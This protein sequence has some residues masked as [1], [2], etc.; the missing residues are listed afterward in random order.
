ME[1][2]AFN[3]KTPHKN[4]LESATGTLVSRGLFLFVFLW[5]GE[6]VFMQWYQKGG[7]E[8]PSY[9]NQHM[10]LVL[11]F[12]PCKSELRRTVESSPEWKSPNSRRREILLYRWAAIFIIH[13]AGCVPLISFYLKE[14]PAHLHILRKRDTGYEAS[15]F[16]QPIFPRLMMYRLT[17]VVM[18][19]IYKRQGLS[20]EG[21]QLP[22]N[23]LLFKDQGRVQ[24]A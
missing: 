3:E 9:G 6:T 2:H 20:T 10:E 7:K 18:L 23:V 11:E 17:K 4:N 19:G 21:W 16:V 14:I 12:L 15:L 13:V 22:F 5:R 1:S 24:E 8:I